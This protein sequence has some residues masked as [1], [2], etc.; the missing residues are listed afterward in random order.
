VEREIRESSTKRKDNDRH[1]TGNDAGGRDANMNRI[2]DPGSPEFY[3][4]VGVCGLDG[5]LEEPFQP[6]LVTLENLYPKAA[7][8]Q[9]LIVYKILDPRAI[10]IVQ[11]EDGLRYFIGVAYGQNTR[12]TDVY[13]PTLI[14]NVLRDCSAI[15]MP[16][17]ESPDAW[18]AWGVIRR[19]LATAVS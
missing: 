13:S 1:D 2:I 19:V 6:F 10:K 9:G 12:M 5:L 7:K 14:Q 3:A 4:A 17:P 15:R 16:P 11:L 18:Y 8:P